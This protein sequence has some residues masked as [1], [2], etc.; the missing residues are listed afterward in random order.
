MMKGGSEMP[1]HCN[2]VSGKNPVRTLTRPSHRILERGDL[3]I[4]ELE[5]SWIGYRSQ[6]VQPT[7]VEVVDP[8]HAE[9]MKV[10]KEIFETLLGYLRPGITVRELSEKTE[11]TCRKAAPKTGPAVGAIGKLTMHGRGQGDDG[12]IIT[13]HAREPHQLAVEL[14]ENMAFIFK[15]SAE[16]ATGP[17]AICTWGDTVVVGGNGGRRL[18]K[19]PHDLAVAG[20]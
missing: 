16:T 13:G 18:G 8:V 10:Q 7:F 3:I 4:N 15:P 1:V 12:P 9:L 5:A 2:W 20:A 6:G 11:E 17:K 19:R 14:K